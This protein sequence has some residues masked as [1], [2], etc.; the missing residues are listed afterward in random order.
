MLQLNQNIFPAQQI[1][2]LKWQ[3]G[4]NQGFDLWPRSLAQ[5]FPGLYGKGPFP[6]LSE[7][8]YNAVI[9]VRNSFIKKFLQLS[10]GRRSLIILH[11]I[12]NLLTHHCLHCEYA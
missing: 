9:S 12:R 3:P 7:L 10:K 5:A 6:Q 8:A 2:I 4:C 1:N 11:G